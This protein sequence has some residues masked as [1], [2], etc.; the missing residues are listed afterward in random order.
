MEKVFMLRF[1]LDGFK[2]E[3]KEYE[4]E[5]ETR[6]LVYLKAEMDDVLPD[7]RLNRYQ[8]NKADV[9]KMTNLSKSAYWFE[10]YG[11]NRNDMIQKAHWLFREEKER[12]QARIRLMDKHGH[13]LELFL[14]K[15]K[16]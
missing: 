11:T 13:D 8:L 14:F 4:V 1:N 16:F 10:I 5:R 9:Y 7:W 2:F 3:F 6:C 15:N 12:A